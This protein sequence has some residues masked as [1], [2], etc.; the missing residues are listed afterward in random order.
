MAYGSGDVAVKIVVSNGLVGRD[1]SPWSLYAQE[2]E[3]LAAPQTYEIKAW[4]RTNSI[5]VIT[6]ESTAM[7]G[8]EA[9]KLAPSVELSA[10]ERLAKWLAESQS[11]PAVPEP[12]TAS[13]QSAKQL[14]SQRASR[15]RRSV[16]TLFRREPEPESPSVPEHTANS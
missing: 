3:V 1:I 16:A 12:A 13:G 2:R 10:D 9:S 4:T 15:L 7:P 8:Y 11:P 5:N 14:S 6:M